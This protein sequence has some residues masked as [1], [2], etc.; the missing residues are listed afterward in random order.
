LVKA[1]PPAGAG[2]LVSADPP[3]GAGVEV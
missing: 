1:E 2:E 3:A